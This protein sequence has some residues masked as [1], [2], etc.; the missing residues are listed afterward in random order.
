MSPAV[1]SNECIC[2]QSVLF[3]YFGSFFKQK[4]ITTFKSGFNI[5]N[6]ETFFILKYIQKSLQARVIDKKI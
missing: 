3:N 2:L 6:Y 5:I 4:I 1:S